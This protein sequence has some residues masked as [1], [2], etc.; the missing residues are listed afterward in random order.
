MKVLVVCFVVLLGTVS[1][2]DWEAWKKHHNKTFHPSEEEHRKGIFQK[3]DDFI[4][5]HNSD[6]NKNFT[7]GHNH[8]SHM[9]MEEV[10]A[11]MMG[12]VIPQTRTE[13]EATFFDDRQAA[14]SIDWRSKGA[15]NPVKDQG[16]CGSCWAFS[17]IAALEGQQFV[18]HGKLVSLSE[19]QLV[20]CS[21]KFGNG[22]CNGGWPYAGFNYLKSVKGS[23]TETS[24]P[25]VLNDYTA[26]PA[27]SC[28]YTTSSATA[29]T[30]TGYAQTAQGSESALQSAVSSVGPLSI[31]IDAALDSFG[32]Y[33]SGIYTDPACSSS[34][35]ATDHCV[36]VVGY[37]GTGT[38]AYWIVRNSWT[39]YWGEAGYIRI[40][41]NMGNLCGVANYATYPTIL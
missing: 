9:T 15:V 40:G 30:V 39:I 6:P 29:V 14:T 5:K 17:A 20:D 22:G 33:S 13:V 2:D 19:E 21:Q 38:Q 23:E 11:Q 36:A 12:A 31:C 18:K 28:R 7:V 37:G 27:Q 35:S 3:T 32:R 24:Y 34:T 26:P 8:F 4:N 41:R 16:Q 10:K 25:Y 1:A